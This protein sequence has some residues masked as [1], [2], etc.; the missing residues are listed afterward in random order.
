MRLCGNDKLIIFINI[1]AQYYVIYWALRYRMVLNNQRF[2]RIRIRRLHEKSVRM[3][4]D[5]QHTM[6]IRI[7]RLHDERAR[8]AEYHRNRVDFAESYNEGGI[9]K[10]EIQ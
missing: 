10:P 5:S 6:R 7:R 8:M 9:W 3:V 4:L 2:L 1:G